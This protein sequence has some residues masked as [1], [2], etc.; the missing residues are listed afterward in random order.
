MFQ[1]KHPADSKYNSE[2]Y[3][4]RSKL[5]RPKTRSVIRKNEA[6]M[7][8]AFFSNM[9]VVNVQPAND[10]DPKQVLASKLHKELLQYRL[11]KSVPWF[12]T[13]I[14]AGQDAMTV[15]VVCSYQHW[16]YR[17]KTTKSKQ[18]YLDE[19]TGAPMMGIDG[20]PLSIDQ[21]TTQ[22]LEDKPAID[23]IPVENLRID[24]GASWTDP[25]NS[26]PYVIHMIP[27]YIGD[28]KGM[29]NANPKTG[30]K[31][32]DVPDDGVLRA[33]TKHS[34][35]TT[36]QVREG[37]REDSKE[38]QGTAINEF[39]IAW[40]HKNIVRRDGEDWCY[41]TLGIEHV[42]T[43]PVPLAKLYPK[44]KR[45]Y[46]MGCAILETHKVYPSGFP[47]LGKEVQKEINEIVNSRQDNVKLVMNKRYIV[48]RGSQTDLKSLVRNVAA[49][50]TLAN[51]PKED[52]HALEFN[53]VTSSAYAEQD[54]LNVDFDELLGNFS[55]SSVMTNR[56]M[57]ETV[58]GM[59]LMGQGA[60]Q[61][62][63][64][65]I[66]TLTET[67]VEP[68]LRQVVELEK[69]YETDEVVLT[70][71]GQKLEALVTDDLFDVDVELN[72]NVGIGATDPIQRINRLL[73]AARSI[74]EIASLNVG[75]LKIGEVSKEVFGAIGYRDGGRFWD[76]GRRS[77]HGADHAGGAAAAG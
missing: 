63:E 70:L 53:D 4:Y 23:L 13:L 69:H 40:V 50:I 48:K 33:A 46:V 76:E 42:L 60:N 1:S 72:V 15:G 11:T 61:L 18:Y 14:G 25:V 73:T 2:A 58:G 55:Q 43:D 45:P 68:V 37:N 36:R 31:G 32:W 74:A 71:M 24:K 28:L 17:E 7:A 16:V 3:K 66:R 12:L 21:E 38:T 10:K 64:Y 6:A 39:E 35:D 30:E 8:A 5:F 47:E 29:A 54:R 49:S 62:T 26:S 34:Y 44:G 52:V 65:T 27:M 20:G 56:K 19:Q 9:D 41:Y 57:N 67:W 77:A 59:Q 75:G 22:V 51:N